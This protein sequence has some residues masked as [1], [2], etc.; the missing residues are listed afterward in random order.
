MRISLVFMLGLPVLYLTGSLKKTVSAMHIS[1]KA[2]VLYFFLAAGLSLLPTFSILAFIHMDAAGAFICVA[3]A[4]YLAYQ[5]EFSYRLFLAAMLSVMLSVAS[6]YI[7]SSYS[8]PYLQ[9]LTGAAVA[10]IGLVCLGKRAAK[11]SPVLAGAY[12][13]SENMMTL[14]TGQVR[15]LRLFD[16]VELAL[17]CTVFCLAA[18]GTGALIDRKRQ[19]SENGKVPDLPYPE[20]PDPGH[21]EQETPEPKIPE[22]PFPGIEF[23]EPELPKPEFPKPELTYPV[24]PK[25]DFPGIKPDVTP[26]DLKTNES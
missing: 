11:T 19:S 7:L 1:G 5:K 9:P 2:F 6:Y 3:P 12:S 14:L 18:I 24:F 13:I 4:V 16:A 23:P 26:P 25:V 22:T 17:L 15:L 21:P 8:V 20:F 10:L